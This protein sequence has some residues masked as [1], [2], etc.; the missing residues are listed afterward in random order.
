MKVD[1]DKFNTV[2]ARLMEARP[3]KRSE[4][5]GGGIGE[6]HHAMTLSVVTVCWLLS[7]GEPLSSRASGRRFARYGPTEP[8]SSPRVH[9]GS[10]RPARGACQSPLVLVY[11]RRYGA[12]L[13]LLIRLAGRTSP[14]A[15]V[16]NGQKS[17]L[18]LTP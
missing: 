5:T 13:R 10:R 9:L 2:L 15:F 7:S 17:N 18:Y 16:E 1:K 12:D 4:I 8:R 11:S 3:E 14:I 6:S